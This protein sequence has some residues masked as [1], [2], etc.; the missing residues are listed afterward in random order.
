VSWAWATSAVELV[1]A[2]SRSEVPAMR[3]PLSAQRGRPEQLFE[4]RV[5]GAQV[6]QG[7]VDVEGNHGRHEAPRIWSM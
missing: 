5:E 3:E 6:K 4:L 2:T 7:L 1:S